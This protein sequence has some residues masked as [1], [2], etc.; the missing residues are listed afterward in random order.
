MNNGEIV[1]SF[2]AGPRGP[3]QAQRLFL[4]PTKPPSQWAPM[5]ELSEQEDDHWSPSSAKVK[6]K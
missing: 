1:V 3:P 6:N 5:V 4:G 2:P